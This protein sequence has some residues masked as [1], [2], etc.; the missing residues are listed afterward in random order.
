MLSLAQFILRKDFKFCTMFSKLKSLLLNEWCMEPDIGALVY[1]LRY[2]PVM[3]KLTILLE[4][5][6]QVC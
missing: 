3:E 6:F 2:S 5:D 4:N 1:F